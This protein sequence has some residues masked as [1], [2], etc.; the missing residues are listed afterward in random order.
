[1]SEFTQVLR[2][3]LLRNENYYTHGNILIVPLR[4]IYFP[5]P[6]VACSSIKKIFA[7][8]LGLYYDLEDID[9]SVHEAPFPYA[10][11]EE[12]ASAKYDDYFKFAFVRNPWDRLYSCYKSKVMPDPKIQVRG[13]TNGVFDGFRKFGNQFRAGMSFAEFVQAVLT[14]DDADA[15]E[16]FRSQYLALVGKDG[17]TLPTFI[18]HLE[19]IDE[20]WPMVASRLGVTAKLPRLMSSC[21]GHSYPTRPYTPLLVEAVAARY[22]EDVSRFGYANQSPQ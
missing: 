19:A 16:H 6:K 11:R 5:I 9:D 2:R 22:A 13:F 18:G 7:D 15:D 8:Y 21:Q 3:L 10:V 4:V 12:I 17:E 1:M 20:E 14:I